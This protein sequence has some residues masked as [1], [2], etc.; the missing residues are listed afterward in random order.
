MDSFKFDYF[1]FIHKDGNTD[2]EITVFRPVVPIFLLNGHVMAR[3]RINCLIDSGS[4]RNLFPAQWGEMVG[5]KINK[6]KLRKIGG[7]GDL[8]PIDAYSHNIS[9]MIGIYKFQTQADFSYT[10]AVP[11]VGR[12]GFFDHF[13]EVR[14]FQKDKVTELVLKRNS[15]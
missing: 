8:A 3:R 1:P 15:F 9:L 7:I 6:G 11:L 13:E 14:F 2:K 12:E 10:Q 4:D 5:I